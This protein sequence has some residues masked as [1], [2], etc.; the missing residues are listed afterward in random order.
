MIILG[1]TFICVSIGLIFVAYLNFVPTAFRSELIADYVKNHFVREV[2]FGLGLAVFTI[3]SALSASS[4]SQLRLVAVFG[5]IVVWPFWI[6]SWL[7]WST[8]G[9]SEVWGG[10]IDPSAAYLL[11]GS[12]ALLFVFGLAILALALRSRLKDEKDTNSIETWWSF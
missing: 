11:H 2:I 9:L 1:K 12:Q 3:R 5:S 6:A 8:G 10:R 4:L 7:G